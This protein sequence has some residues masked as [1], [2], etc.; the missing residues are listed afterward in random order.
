MLFRSELFSGIFEEAEDKF[1]VWKEDLEN[2]AEE[3]KS[4]HKSELD[5]MKQNRKMR[6]HFDRK[7]KEKYNNEFRQN[8]KP[9]ILLWDG[10]PKGPK[11]H[12]RGFGQNG[13][14]TYNSPNP[15]SESTK[16]Y[17]TIVKSG[18]Y[19]LSVLNSSG[20]EVSKL[21][22]GEL[23]EGEHSFTFDGSDQNPGVYFYKVKGEGCEQTGKMMLSR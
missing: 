11:L 18:D 13:I 22:S 3:W 19:D 15:F 17:V 7:F 16:I 10:A 5:G 23:S 1:E 9:R 20:E 6:R 14:K 8:Y 21:H 4:E 2:I 12:G